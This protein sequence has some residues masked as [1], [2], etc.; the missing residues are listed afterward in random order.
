MRVLLT[1]YLPATI[2]LHILLI[3]NE[4]PLEYIIA[5][6]VTTLLA[7][8]ILF[9][10]LRME[11]SQ[12]LQDAEEV[13]DGQVV[14]GTESPPA[15]RDFKGGSPKNSHQVIHHIES[16]TSP[17]YPSIDLEPIDFEHFIDEQNLGWHHMVA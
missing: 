12:I 16:M 5:D 17:Q 4:H 9:L 8:V 13:W 2:V 1:G 6:G 7:I 15:G 14:S 11:C 3:P 10:L